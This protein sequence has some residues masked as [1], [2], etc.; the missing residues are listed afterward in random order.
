M[1][2]LQHWVIPNGINSMVVILYS[3]N[4]SWYIDLFVIS[5]RGAQ[6]WPSNKI[7][8]LF[9]LDSQEQLLQLSQCPLHFITHMCRAET[10]NISV[11]S[12]HA[13]EVFPL[14]SDRKN[15]ENNRE[16]HTKSYLY[17]L[18]LCIRHPW[19]LVC[20]SLWHTTA[21]TTLLRTNTASNK[22]LSLYCW[23]HPTRSMGDEGRSARQRETDLK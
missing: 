12:L 23:T 19:L 9:V 5:D 20:T 13:L 14:S 6:Q 3:F 1:L 17:S 16:N 15:T 11:W 22:C 21:L 18:L 8:N 4:F 2:H 10:S 7:T